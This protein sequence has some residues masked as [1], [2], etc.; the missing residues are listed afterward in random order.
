MC[1]PC[2]FLFD[3]YRKPSKNRYAVYID[4]P[5]RDGVTEQVKVGLPSEWVSDLMLHASQTAEYSHA[6]VLNI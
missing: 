2:S 6:F 3:I 5:C 4:I 1:D